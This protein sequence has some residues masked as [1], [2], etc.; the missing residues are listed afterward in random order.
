MSNGYYLD[1]V[2]KCVC[3]IFDNRNPPSPIGTG[4]FASIKLDSDYVV[5]LVTAKHVLQTDL[6]HY[7]ERILYRLNTKNNTSKYVELVLFL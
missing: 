6:G 1:Q 2:K 4:F 5:Y 3:F 7:R